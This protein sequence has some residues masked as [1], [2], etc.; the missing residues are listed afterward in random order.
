MINDMKL[1]E[2][3]HGN[4][5]KKILLDGITSKEKTSWKEFDSYSKL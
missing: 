1:H 4:R 5:W 3:Y 2:S